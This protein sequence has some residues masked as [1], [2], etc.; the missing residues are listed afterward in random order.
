MIDIPDTFRQGAS[1]LRNARDWAREEKDKLITS[2]NNIEHGARST[3]AESP[4]SILS[5]S[6]I[7]VSQVDSDASTDELAMIR[8]PDA[9]VVDSFGASSLLTHTRL[10]SGPKAR[11]ILDYQ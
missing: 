2:A 11:K 3:T 1:A 4:A 6:I 7:G 8:S 5:P 10:Y 9:R